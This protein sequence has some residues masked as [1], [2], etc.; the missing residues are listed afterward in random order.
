MGLILIT[1]DLGVVAETAQRVI[2]MYAGRKVEEA[3]VE[4]LFA[5]PRHP[6]TRGLLASIPTVP[7]HGANADVRLVRNSRHGAVADEPAAGLRV[8]AALQLAI[9]AL[10]RRISAACRIWR[11]PSGG[12]LARRRN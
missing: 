1:H 11:R 10:P 3:P 5:N 2:V 6:Y 12:L 8:R 4:A 7:S 9:D